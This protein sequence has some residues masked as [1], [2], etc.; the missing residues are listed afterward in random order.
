MK[1]IGVGF[2]LVGIVGLGVSVETNRQVA[3][4]FRGGGM[5]LG[6]ESFVLKVYDLVSL[7]LVFDIASGEK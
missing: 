7:S 4:S 2:D 1:V 5:T 3:E 6:G